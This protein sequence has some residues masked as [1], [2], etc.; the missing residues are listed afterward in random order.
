LLP[1]KSLRSL[2]YR[3][4]PLLAGKVKLQLGSGIVRIAPADLSEYSVG[5]LLL[6]Y[7]AF[8]IAVWNGE[9]TVERLPMI[10]ILLAVFSLLCF[11]LIQRY[12]AQEQRRELFLMKRHAVDYF[13][14]HKSPW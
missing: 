12:R 2:E 7:L 10:P 11:V 8:S 6:V 5:M 13:E 9:I 1:P 4:F 3:R 14:A